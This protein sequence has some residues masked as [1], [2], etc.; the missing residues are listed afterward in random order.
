MV[1]R[2][3]RFN[4]KSIFANKCD[5]EDEHKIS[6]EYCF[7]FADKNSISTFR[8]ECTDGFQ[9]ALKTDFKFSKVRKAVNTMMPKS[10]S[11]E[12]ESKEKSG[13]LELKIAYWH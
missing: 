2:D 3:V 1:L 7:T 13:C 6:A 12:A 9:A 11:N 10:K 8:N 5:L 4:L